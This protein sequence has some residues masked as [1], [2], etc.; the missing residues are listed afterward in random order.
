MTE[1]TREARL[2]SAFVKLA[3]TLTDEYDVVDLLH[4]LVIECTAILDTQAGGI[5]LAD[6]N[7]ELQLIASTSEKADLVE[8]M[9]LNAGQGPCVD[10]FATGEPVAVPDI[11]S[12]HQWPAFRQEALKQ[13]FRSLYATPMRLRGEIIGTLNLMSTRVGNLNLLDAQAAQALTDVATIGILQQ[14]LIHERGIV[15][16]QLQRALD[17]R[18]LIEQ[19]KGVLSQMSNISV[20]DAFDAMRAYARTNNLRLREVADRIVNRTIDVDSSAFVTPSSEL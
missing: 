9:Q 16:E 15:A 20:D 3:D 12:A 2:N 11:D 17:S 5:M 10:C 14:R 7:G 13:G 4:T 19:A 18:I 1:Q 6:T 8:M